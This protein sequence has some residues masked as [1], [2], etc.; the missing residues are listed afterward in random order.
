[1]QTI[2]IKKWE[3][4]NPQTSFSL[5]DDLLFPVGMNMAI[6]KAREIAPKEP[7][8]SKISIMAVTELKIKNAK[9]YAVIMQIAITQ[10]MRLMFCFNITGIFTFT[11]D[12]DLSPPYIFLRNELWNLEA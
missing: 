7:L 2:N 4:D 12:E 1:M 9:E 6:R 5:I 11:G 10:N 8:K 3:S